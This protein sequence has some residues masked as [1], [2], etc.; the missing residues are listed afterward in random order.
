MGWT[1][2]PSAFKKYDA[3]PNDVIVFY[4]ALFQ[5]KF[6]PKSRTYNKV[7]IPITNLYPP[8]MNTYRFKL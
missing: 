5:S 6:E 8:I 7:R 2:D 1:S 3:K 4:P